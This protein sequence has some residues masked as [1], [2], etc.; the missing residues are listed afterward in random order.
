[1]ISSDI[2]KDFPLFR[3]NPDIAYLDNAAT[4]QKP[5]SVLDAVRDYYEHDNANPL[6][7]LYDLAVRATEDYEM[8]REKVAYL[9]GAKP[10]E[11]VFTRN[12]TEGLNFASHSIADA[13]VKAGDEIL[14]TIMEH[15]SNLLVW[16]QAAKRLGAKLVYIEPEEEGLIRNERFRSN[17]TPNT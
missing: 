4:T 15:H 10:S 5:Q 8:A 16:Q 11:I 14:I 12:A 7:G 2:R 3:N 6:R 13:Y 9:L 1:M 17:L